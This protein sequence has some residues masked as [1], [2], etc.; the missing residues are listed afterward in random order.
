MFLTGQNTR[1]C[2]V[3]A[4]TGAWLERQCFAAEAT[5]I[6]PNH[7]KR[8]C[9][10]LVSF[11]MMTWVVRYAHLRGRFSADKE[12]EGITSLRLGCPERVA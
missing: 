2:A 12:F 6:R 9:R 8:F 11:V 1:H 3:G 10:I 5:A 4:G 7:A